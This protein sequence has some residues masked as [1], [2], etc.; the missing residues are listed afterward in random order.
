[1][2]LVGGCARV[3]LGVVVLLVVGVGVTGCNRNWEVL[4][5]YSLGFEEGEL[6]LAVCEAGPVTRVYLTKT[7][8]EDRSGEAPT[9]W[10]AEGYVQ[11]EKGHVFV[12]GGVNDGLRNVLV[13][14]P[15]PVTEVRDYSVLFNEGDRATLSAVFYLPDSGLGEGEWLTPTGELRDAP[16]E[17]E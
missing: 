16:C 1:M 10:E 5:P 7:V 3:A 17:A 6:L 9:V 11:A 12:V 4:G 8:R 15:L 2:R 13:G 14:E